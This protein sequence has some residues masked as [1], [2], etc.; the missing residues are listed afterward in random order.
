MK[1][2]ETLISQTYFVKKL[3]VFRAVPLFIIRSFP[4]YIRHWYMS[5]MFDDRFQ[6][7]PGRSISNTLFYVE[8]VSDIE[9]TLL[10]TGRVRYRTHSSTYRTCSI[11]NTLFY[12]QD[13][14]EIE[15]TLLRTGRVP[16]RTNTYTYQTDRNCLTEGN[17]ET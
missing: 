15:H 5:C 14:F 4:L 9:H 2:K 16:D 6:E 12:V 8:G 13:V 10:R 1:L 11:S 3:Y 7:R 17:R